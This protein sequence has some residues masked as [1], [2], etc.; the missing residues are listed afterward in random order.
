MN[1]EKHKSSF[2]PRMEKVKPEF[3]D[4]SLIGNG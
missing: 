1:T 4:T 2:F 3:D